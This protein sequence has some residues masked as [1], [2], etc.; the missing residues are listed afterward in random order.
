MGAEEENA[1]YRGFVIGPIGNRFAPLGTSGRETYEDALEIF[2]KVIVPACEAN[3]VEPIRADQIAQPGEINEQIFRHL[4]TAD[5][6]IA[7]LSGGN[8]NVMY[9][10][11]LRHTLNKLTIQIGE[12]GQLPFDIAAVR[13]IQFSR[14]DR[15][16]I[17][18][19]KE[20]QKAI[21]AGLT[22]GPDEVTA[23]RVWR[24]GLEGAIVEPTPEQPSSEAEPLDDSDEDGLLERIVGLEKA[25]PRATA[26]TVAIA[27]AIA[28]MGEEATNSTADL[29]N[30][31]SAGANAHARVAVV[32][33]YATALQPR[34]D[35]LSRLTQQFHDDMVELDGSVSGTLSIMERNP[36]WLG[37]SDYEEF[38]QSISTTARVSRET[39]ANA[40]QFA[41]A[42]RGLGD[43]SRILRRPANQIHQAMQRM[44]DA[45]ALTDSWDERATRLRRRAL[46][47]QGGE[48]N[49]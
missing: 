41:E 7:D 26:T 25:F 29:V 4:R 9:E 21:D 16:L 23:T 44:F 3:S 27:E 48:G 15:G 34:A 28:G 35:E 46:E 40:G 22:E 42:V 1:K 2:E 43:M 8:P 31:A 39:T 11:G 10:L 38:L 37:R 17:D 12:F 49:D 18:A 6:V 5:V 20:L 33:R 19:R 13:T 24:S 36:T 32:A 14:S 45:M 30:A 47:Q